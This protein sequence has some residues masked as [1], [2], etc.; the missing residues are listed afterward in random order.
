MDQVFHVPGMKKNLF[1]VPQVTSTGKY[2]LF[3]PTDVKIFEKFETSS[4]P[5]LQGK[6]NDT[7]YVLSA[8]SVYVEKAKQ[9]ETADLWHARLSHVGYDRL[10]V[11]MKKELVRGL[12]S[13]EIKKEVVCAGCQY[14]K[15]HQLPYEL[16]EHKTKELLEIIHSD[17]LGPIKQASNTG[18]RYMVSFIDDYT[19][20]VWLDF[21]QEKSEVFSKF[22]LFKE[23]AE[24]QTGKLIKCLRS[25]NGGEYLSNEFDRFL[26]EHKIKRQL[27]CSNTLQQNG[28]SERKN[29]HFGETCRSILHDK[30]VPGKYWAEGMKTVCYVINRLPAQNL[31]YKS[32]FEKLFGIKPNISHLRVFGSV[33]YVFV[34]N[35]LR[36]KMEKKAIRC[37][38]IGYDEQRKGWRCC[39]PTTNKCYVYRNVVFDE[40]SSWWST[41]KEN[42]PDTGELKGKLETVILSLDQ[43]KEIDTV[44]VNANFEDHEQ[45]PART[46]SQSR[47]WQSGTRNQAQNQ[48]HTVDSEGSPTGPRRSERVRRPNPKYVVNLASLEPAVEEPSEFEEAKNNPEWVKA[49]KDEIDAMK[50]NETWVLVPKPAEVKPVTCKWVYKIKRKA[51]GCVERFKA[52]LVARGFSQQ[53]RIDYEDTFSLV[54]KLATVRVIISIA[55]SKRWIM[56]QMDVSNAFLYGD[57]DHTI[58]MEHPR[59]FEDKEHPSYVCKL[60]KA[61]YGLKQSP[62][63]WFGK[64][65]EFL[66]HND[67]V[68]SKSDASLFV[69]ETRNRVVV[70]LIY[71][72][73]LIITGDDE[74]G[75]EQV[76]ENLCIR[77]YMKDLGILSHFLGLELKYEDDSVVLHQQKYSIELLQRFGMVDCKPAMTPS[78]TT[79]KLCVDRGSKLED[80]IMYRQIVGSLIYLTLGPDIS[81]IVG[82]LSRY[83]QQP[84]K[85]HLDALRRVLRYVK[86]TL[87]YGIVFKRGEKLELIG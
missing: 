9:N 8:E 26:R 37:I 20:Y 15:A 65:G 21:M 82:V 52:R 66:L 64:I 39:D 58:H 23:E 47:P 14:G 53:Y 85:P 29:R 17:V 44:E 25:D 19:R 41:S 81:F 1:S 79:V 87:G 71:V 36:E 46:Q 60:R 6:R 72:D 49:M 59:G 75:I 2:G 40:N 73:D 55:T 80:P 76:K 38:F 70:V 78:D 27:T 61:I 42:L 28:V 7:V 84:R 5:I 32:P 67:F 16:S 13:L 34:P 63:A 68:M 11:M 10:E 3:G 31:E 45:S 30:N 74:D 22:K 62:R 18:K 54:A 33:C 56:H 24:R 4:V 69:R 83:M 86:A 50:R 51:D 43:N 57:L 77:F 35:H 12:P 48:V